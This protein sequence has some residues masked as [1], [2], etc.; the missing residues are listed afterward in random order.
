MP[1][2]VRA[3]CRLISDSL[4]YQVKSVGGPQISG[5]S[6]FLWGDIKSCDDDNEQDT[7]TEGEALEYFE[8]I[9]ALIDKLNAEYVSPKRKATTTDLY[10]LVHEVQ[11]AEYH[12]GLEV[13]HDRQSGCAGEAY[14]ACK[15]AY[16]KLAEELGL[17]REYYT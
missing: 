1:E 7:R 14:D 9:T 6:L 3:T 12:H 4:G 11:K 10:H 16:E 15:K 17:T 8:H 13:G 5:K 2:K